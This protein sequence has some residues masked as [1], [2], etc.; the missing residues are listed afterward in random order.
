MCHIIFRRG[1]QEG[2][3]SKDLRGQYVERSLTYL[4]RGA[5]GDSK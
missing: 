1:Q 2:E 3:S 5:G 4:L